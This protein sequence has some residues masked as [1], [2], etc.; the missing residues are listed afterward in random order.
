[1]KKL[2]LF[3]LVSTALIY[4]QESSVPGK[5]PST[6]P[7]PNTTTA[8]PAA[9]ASPAPTTASAPVAQTP[10]A[11]QKLM[12]MFSAIDPHGDPIANVA[13]SQLSIMDNGHLAKVMD[14]QP[15]P[16]LPLD[17]GIVLLGRVDF[18]QQQAAAIELVKT[19]RPGKDRAFVMVAGGDKGAK[20]E[21]PWFSDQ[22]ALI[23]Q[24]K[25]LDK[26]VGY[27]DPFEYKMNRS[28][29]GLERQQTQEYSA[30]VTSFF[31][32]AWQNYTASPR[33]A[34]RV[35]V[36][37]RT[38][39][40][41]APGVSGRA[42]EAAQLR[43]MHVVQG[44]QYFRTPIFIVGI[45]DLGTYI[46]GPKDIGQISVSVNGGSGDAADMRSKDRMMQ[47]F[48]EDQYEGGRTNLNEIAADSG[49][50]SYWTKKYTDAIASIKSDLTVPYVVSFMASAP[51]EV[52]ALKLSAGPDARLAVQQ[53]LVQQVPK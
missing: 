23:N 26:H 4:A 30:D 34:R 2:C 33:F 9:P 28:A 19:L 51:A 52:H 35:L 37:F 44:S 8:A 25:N 27:P 17:L 31:D 13:K 21:L 22:A 6:G 18:A 5:T 53:T 39:M 50:R 24:I 40:G 7:A 29:A 1:M 10:A 42:K 15:M 11:E 36:V 32:F 16:D 20:A 48:I 14:L 46:S 41:H 47:R 12:L 49:G 38:P 45:E 43:Q 3:L